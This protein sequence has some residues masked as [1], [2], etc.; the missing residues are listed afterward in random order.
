MRFLLKFVCVVALV[1][2]CAAQAHTESATDKISSLKERV[3][4]EIALPALGGTCAASTT[5]SGVCIDIK[6]TACQYSLVSNKCAGAANIKCCSTAPLTAAT[7]TTAAPAASTSVAAPAGLTGPACTGHAGVCVD[8]GVC[9][10]SGGTYASGFCPKFANNV[11]CCF[12]STSNTAASSTTTTA[13]PAAV[14]QSS[15]A[16][17][18]C[19]LSNGVRGSCVT[20]TVCASVGG[21]THKGFC[22]NLPANVMCCVGNN[23]PLPGQ[24]TPATTAP[25]TSSI[26]APYDCK[27]YGSYGNC[28]AITQ[29]KTGKPYP[30]FCP[31]P[32]SV[33]C[34]VPTATRDRG[35][36]VPGV[37]ASKAAK[38]I[39]K[40]AAERKSE[41]EH[42]SKFNLFRLKHGRTYTDSAK[43]YKVFKENR[44]RIIDMNDKL[45]S[46]RAVFSSNTKFADLTPEQFRNR[47]LNALP[48]N[49]PIPPISL[50]EQEHT[51]D[52]A[53]LEVEDTQG[54]SA[55][56]DY[57]GSGATVT[58]TLIIDYRNLLTPI[59]NQ[60]TCGSCYAHSV[61]E[62]IESQVIRKYG[63]SKIL[64]P[65]QLVDCTQG[66]DF[67]HGCMNG[68]TSKSFKYLTQHRTC[69]EA[70]YPYI[71]DV[72]ETCVKPSGCSG[73][74]LVKET[75]VVA[76][77][78]AQFQPDCKADILQQV[79][80]K[81]LTEYGPLSVVVDA[82][83][84][85]YFQGGQIFNTQYCQSG[86][87]QT[88]HAVQLV[89]YGYEE[90]EGVKKYFWLV[91]NSY[92]SD[93]GEQG[94]IRIEATN[95]SC[96]IVNFATVP[97]MA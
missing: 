62:T 43:A 40:S 5:V 49:E 71:N 11:K 27:A 80:L 56:T 25:A 79:L 76:G 18:G 8:T 68:Y 84:W 24:S 47:Y 17:P 57:T 66:L 60:Q 73:G 7:A 9:T 14:T 36:P 97:I 53:L 2:V 67:N 46:G 54:P 48:P 45:K 92:G 35:A 87:G 78:V 13:A 81:S 34:C 72:R 4:T 32:A 12:K 61:M 55:A 51:F 20:N 38:K 70:E 86:M 63:K 74:Y 95:G 28:K 15:A 69:T 65:Q 37:Y 31:G 3:L 83:N 23:I 41:A 93:W 82:G 44:N 30:G 90:V 42:K 26:P 50:I 22:P 6:K 91:R 85:Q 16:A 33:Q 52:P 88:N 64:A 21:T 10:K 59:K 58:G 96:G 75:K 39:T 77:C 29:C 1:C 19:K 94:Y 89:G